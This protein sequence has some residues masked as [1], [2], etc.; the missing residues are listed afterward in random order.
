MC[1]NM[2]VNMESSWFIFRRMHKLQPL[3][4]AFFK[5]FQTYYDQKARKV[6]MLLTSTEKKIAK[7]KKKR[8]KEE[9]KLMKLIEAEIK[10]KDQKDRKR[11]TSKPIDEV[12]ILKRKNV[13]KIETCWGGYRVP[14]LYW[15]FLPIRRGPVAVRDMPQMGTR[16]LCKHWSRKICLWIL[17]VGLA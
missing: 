11:R 8:K 5:P 6:K 16:V 2:Q 10:S 17:S 4:V 13:D 7:E 1:W 9:K 14:Y 3:D 15:T 12:K